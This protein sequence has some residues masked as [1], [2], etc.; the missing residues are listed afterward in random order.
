MTDVKVKVDKLP[1]HVANPS[2][3]ALYNVAYYND[4]YKSPS[5]TA[6]IAY[7]LAERDPKYH[8]RLKQS[9]KAGT[10]LAEKSLR[11]L[12][13]KNLVKR[14]MGGW[15]VTPKGRAILRAVRA[16]GERPTTFE[17]T[18]HQWTLE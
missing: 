4:D 12:L 14:V 11:K 2:L 15:Y 18:E 9:V 7:E 10:P 16:S 3:E 6:D 8:Y 1:R 5:S 17:S 13:R